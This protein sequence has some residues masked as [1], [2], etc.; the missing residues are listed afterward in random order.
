MV[1]K[2]QPNKPQ[3]SPTSAVLVGKA[4]V[5]PTAKVFALLEL[6]SQRNAARLTDLAT[7]LGVPKTTLYRI[8]S[9]L[10]QLGYLQRE[11]DGRHLTI[12]PRLAKLSADILGASMHLAPRHAI[13]ER[14]SAGLGESCSLGIRI[15]H[16]IVYLDDVT[17]PSPLSFRFGTGQRV[18]LH[19]TST[20]KL[21]LAH[22]RSED[23]D[24]FLRYQE[25]EAYT[26][27][28]ITDPQKLRDE[29]NRII[30]HGCAYSQ[31]EYVVGV[32]GAAAPVVD[33]K[34]CLL[35]GITVSIPAARMAYDD[36]PK[37]APALLGAAAEL[38]ETFNH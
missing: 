23:L 32:I 10:E 13:L 12:A 6:L 22:M 1:K 8:T 19:C 31:G 34:G 35:A 20:G 38:A 21:Y 33:A 5:T 36:L 16:Q 2:Q 25:L 30:D 17:A 14:L 18:P 28:T 26:A 7:A 29:L 27:N 11:P 9:Q 15:G 3:A 24:R 4:D 37:L